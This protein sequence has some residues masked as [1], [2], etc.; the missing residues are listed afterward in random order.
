MEK[1]KEIKAKIDMQKLDADNIDKE[2][3]DKLNL[4]GNIVGPNVP[5]FKDEEQNEVRVTWGVKSDI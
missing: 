4:I 2:R 3:N 5:I 1:T